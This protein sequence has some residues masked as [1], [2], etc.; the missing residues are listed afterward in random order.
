MPVPPWS[1]ILIAMLV[2]TQAMNPT[3][4][5]FIWFRSLQRPGWLSLQIWLPA[6]WF[7]INITFYLSALRCW[8]RSRNWSWVV[9][10]MILLILLRSHPYVICRMRSLPS[11]LL[12]WLIS[13]IA[14]LVLAM[15]VRPI[16]PTA[17]LLL[18]PA[19]LWTPVEAVI[20]Y[21]MIGLNSKQSRSDRGPDDRRP[22]RSRRL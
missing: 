6:A 1:L 16:A 4:R 17:S 15:L 13:W 20:T 11:G 18:L 10:Y 9:A 12:F 19:L 5:D 3:E 8:E 21:Q 14:N 2:V 22:A 7:V